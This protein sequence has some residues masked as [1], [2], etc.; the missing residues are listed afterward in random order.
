MFEGTKSREKGDDSGRELTDEEYSALKDGRAYT[1]K[2]GSV[3]YYTAKRLMP[4]NDEKFDKFDRMVS[5]LSFLEKNGIDLKRTKKATFNG[6]E[7]VVS[8][9]SEMFGPEDLSVEY[10]ESEKDMLSTVPG[11]VVTEHPCGTLSVRS[12][13]S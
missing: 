6:I 1:D 4:G 5:I 3:H 10:F 2:H 13:N 11:I 7:E 12:A 8:H 9:A